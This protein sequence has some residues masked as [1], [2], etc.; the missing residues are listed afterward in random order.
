MIAYYVIR[1]V[2]NMSYII[3]LIDRLKISVIKSIYTE[4]EKWYNI[5]NF[6]KER[7]AVMSQLRFSS[8]SAPYDALVVAR[9]IIEYSN[10]KD[11]GIDNLKLQKLLYYCQ[12]HF[13]CD[14]VQHVRCF[15]EDLKA[16]DWGPVVPNVYRYYSAFG[17][18][19][20]PSLKNNRLFNINESPKALVRMIEED[21][22]KRIKYVVDVFKDLSSIELMKKTHRESPWIEARKTESKIITDD[23]IRK[24]YNNGAE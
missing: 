22:F 15:N 13:L 24:G 8:V 19:P 18:G 4:I 5:L 21:D 10:A 1:K 2:K 17:A 6:R 20:I 16:W 14:S 12:V 9:Q 3:N 11:Y 23:L 7:D